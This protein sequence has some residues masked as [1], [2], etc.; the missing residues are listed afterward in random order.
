MLIRLTRPDDEVERDVEI[1]FHFFTWRK[2]GK[3]TYP[4][5]RTLLG[6]G[7]GT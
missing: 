1:H 5:M 3:I 6:D 4:N 7:G 2:S